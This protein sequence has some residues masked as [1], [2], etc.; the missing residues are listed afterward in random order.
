MARKPLGDA[1]GRFEEPPVVLPGNAHP[2][3]YGAM[4]LHM[5]RSHPSFGW[6]SYM[7]TAALL[8]MSM[9]PSKDEYEAK[10][11]PSVFGTGQSYEEVLLKLYDKLS[12]RPV[13]W[14]P[15]HRIPTHG[16]VEVVFHNKAPGMIAS[17]GIP[18]TATVEAS[19]NNVWGWAARGVIGW[20]PVG[21]S[22]TAAQVAKPKPWPKHDTTPPPDEEEEP[23][24]LPRKGRLTLAAAPAPAA[25][26]ARPQLAM[27]LPPSPNES[28]P[29]ASGGKPGGKPRPTLQT[30]PAALNKAPTRKGFFED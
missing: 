23:A 27:E 19:D 12:D 28:R 10:H 4:L 6:A 20:R 7:E 25:R 13:P 18:P 15:V 14:Q 30:P 2:Y 3:A 17:A 1:D 26:P 5:A 16:K 29:G 21:S 22:P 8:I 24:P 11:G 9:S